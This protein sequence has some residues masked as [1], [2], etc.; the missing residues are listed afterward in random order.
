MKNKENYIYKDLNKAQ[1]MK[2]KRLF[3]R[4]K[5]LV[6][7]D[8]VKF[9]TFTLNNRFLIKTDQKTRER[10]IKNYLN[11]YAD[12]YILNIDFGTKTNREHYHAIATPKYK[13]F[14]ITKFAKIYGFVNVEPIGTLKRYEN[15]NKTLE[16][17][18]ERLTNHAIKDSTQNNRII[19]SR[20]Q[21]KH[22][23][24][25]FKNKLRIDG[26]IENR[27]YEMKKQI[28]AERIEFLKKCGISLKRI[29]E[30]DSIE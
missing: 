9:L 23:E 19:Y 6:N 20:K 4:V 2:Y 13:L 1:K 17:L 21:S 30:L 5:E 22:Q 11:I 8:N 24:L 10:Y 15:I 27:I 28:Q 18:T 25:S 3:N 12:D 29:K 16:D 26:I 14:D 7:R